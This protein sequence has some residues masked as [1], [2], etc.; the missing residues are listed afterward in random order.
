MGI[1]NFG[2]PGHGSSS[3]Y[4]HFIAPSSSVDNRVVAV[5]TGAPTVILPIENRKTII[6]QVFTDCWVKFGDIDASIG[7]GL[8]LGSGAIFGL[9]IL[10]GVP[11]SIIAA[12]VAGNVSVVQVGG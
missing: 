7:D 6:L 11:V 8:L 9:D 12:T 4:L 2:S 10:S 5:A 3:E 1:D